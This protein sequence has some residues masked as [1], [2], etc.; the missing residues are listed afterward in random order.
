MTYTAPVDAAG[1][2]ELLALREAMRIPS[3]TPSLAKTFPH[4]SKRHWA[5]ES[6]LPVRITRATR[7][8]AHVGGMV[9]EGCS[10]KDMER[11][12]CNHRVHVEVIKEILGTLWAFRLLG[13]LPSDTVYLEHDQIAALV[14]EGTRRP[15]DTRD[16]MA[17]WFTSRHTVD[18]LQAFRRGKDA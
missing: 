7:R 2:A 14:A 11:V 10:V 8:L 3:K 15:D 9:P 5:R 13:W 16:L 12:R 6:P 17:E 18:E 4:P 1:D